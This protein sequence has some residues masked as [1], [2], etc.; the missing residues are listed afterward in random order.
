MVWVEVAGFKNNLT[1]YWESLD[2]ILNFLMFLFLQFLYWNSICYYV[3]LKM[4]DRFLKMIEILQSLHIFVISL[5]N[6]LS[7]SQ[8][9]SFDLQLDYCIVEVTFRPFR[10]IIDQILSVEV[11]FWYV[12]SLKVFFWY[13]NWILMLCLIL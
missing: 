3:Q 4:V 1:F 10:L 7:I 9:M 2:L 5:I 12:F 8:I 13:P 6:Y 11:I